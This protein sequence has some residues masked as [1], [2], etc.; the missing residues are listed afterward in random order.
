MEKIKVVATLKLQNGEE[1]VLEMSLLSLI[2]WWV[3]G[4]DV[5]AEDSKVTYCHIGNLDI[6]FYFKTFGQMMQV[7]AG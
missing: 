4:D 7:L 5:P 1:R 3:M 2:N 6:N